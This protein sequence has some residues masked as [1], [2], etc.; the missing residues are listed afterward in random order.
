MARNY[1]T[2]QRTS[3]TTNVESHESWGT[4]G[5]LGRWDKREGGLAGSEDTKVRPAGLGEIALGG[6]QTAEDVTVSRLYDLTRDSA[7]ISALRAARGKADMSVSQA[8]LDKHENPTGE[9]DTWTGVLMSVD[10][11]EAD[12]TS[13]D[14][15]E[16]VLV[17]SCDSQVVRS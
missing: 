8:V 7:I 12:T 2:K 16:V 6:V 11:V 17:M 14:E 4:L 3:V 5:N 15:A 9:L 1:A 13:T 10:T